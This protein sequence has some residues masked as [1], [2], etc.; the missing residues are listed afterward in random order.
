MFK[1]TKLGV[2]LGLGFAFVALVLVVAVLTSIWQVG[3]TSTVTNRVMELRAPTAQSSLAMLNGINHSLAALRGWIIL[4]KDK[5]KNERS[6]AWSDEI[7]PALQTMKAFAVNWTNPKN[8]ERLRVIEENLS[9]FNKFQ[10]EIEDIAQIVENTPALKILFQQA[11]PQAAILVGNIT[12]MIDAELKLSVQDSWNTYQSEV[13]RRQDLILRITANFGYGGLIHSF[14]NYVLRGTPKYLEKVRASHSSITEAVNE[15]SSVKDLTADEKDAL[16]TVQKITNEYMSGADHVNTLL[17]EFTAISDL[18]KA[19]SIN[20]SPAFAA[21][22]TLN[23]R[24]KTLVLQRGEEMAAAVKRKKMLG[25]MADVRGTTGL[26]LANIRAYL[27]SGDVKFAKLF[28]KFWAKN[29]KRFGDLQK[30]AHLLTDEQKVAFEKFSAARKAFD[31]L[32]PKMFK[33]RGSAEW[34]LANSWLG[35]KAAPTAFKIKTQLDAMA[36]NQKTLMESD[37]KEAKRLTALLSTLEWIL[38]FAG[39]ILSVVIGTVITRA[40]TG[41]VNRI[42][43]DLSEGSHQVSAAAGE[44]SSSSQSMASGATQ[45]AS[46]IEETSAA[47]E[48]L[49]TQTTKNATSAD[50]A[51]NLSSA[52]TQ[53]ANKGNSTVE[54]M[55]VSMNEMNESSKKIS[56]I[57]K[58]IDEIA[59][60]TNLL[61]LNAAV[62]AARA[63]EHGKGFAVVAEEVRNLAQRSANAAKDTASLIED[64][65]KKTDEGTKMA[66]ESGAVL[67][68]IVVNSEKATSLIADIAT[69]SKEQADGVEQINKA[70][71]EMD[72]ITQS[73]AAS[74]EETAAA[75][76]E[77]SAQSESLL[78]VVGRLNQIIKGKS[79]VDGSQ[80]RK[81]I[82]PVKTKKQKTPTKAPQ[83][84]LKAQQ[85]KTVTPEEVIPMDD[86]DFKDF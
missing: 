67:K 62:E 42:I 57:I 83:K 82:A 37:I 73:N 19:V 76:E 15:Y 29:T 75:S 27:L 41:P 6:K 21:F 61:A 9:K 56:N 48:E 16:A 8:I 68:D 26:G 40:I 33:I 86:S 63:G 65:I 14:K 47:L 55:I 60:Q 58:V 4:G 39:I 22:K 28:E 45:Q 53:T 46:S 1:D 44:I 38:L 81:A 17:G 71:A 54:K 25:M 31:P 51:N 50:E 77:M 2:K 74:A 66:A 10:K 20:D 32:P 79:V 13:A 84:Q 70:V 59:F 36:A 3:K 52:A 69:A 18:D 30:N 80:E 78:D 23:S 85:A 34:N 24:Y 35:T 43:G 11:A 7:D 64:S 12:K 49:S 72:K 5:F